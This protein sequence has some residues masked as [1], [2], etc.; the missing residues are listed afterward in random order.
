MTGVMATEAVFVVG[1]SRSG[2]T[3]MRHILERSSFVSVCRENHFLGHLVR[4]EGVRQQLRRRFGART[5][6]RTATRIV[7]FIYGGG[8]E[9]AS[10][11][12]GMSRQWRW[13]VRHVPRDVFLE[14]FLA[15]D[16]SDRALF[17]IVLRTYAEHER[18]PIIGEKT[19][20]H[21][22]YVETIFDWFPGARVVHMVR[23]PRAIYVSELRRRAA[24]HRSAPYRFLR[25]APP[26]LAA[27]VLLETTFAWLESVARLARHRSRHRD[28]YLAVRFEDLVTA[29]ERV[30]RRICNFLGVP[31]E[32]A[33]LEQ[34]VVS[35]GHRVGASGFDRAA[36][37]RWRDRIGPLARAW[38]RVVL[39]PRMRRLGY[40]A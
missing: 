40:R 7:D 32:E 23:D 12:R 25:H 27:F 5:D 18:K 20:A 15:S 14:R 4:R 6:D 29:P 10:R 26:L 31:F 30:V 2:T 9:S 34:I 19:P 16:R 13:T 36:A 1:V 17:D 11:L 37:G 35:R 21:V 33:M 38:F 3:L 28:R 24:E 39:G 8:L 22:R